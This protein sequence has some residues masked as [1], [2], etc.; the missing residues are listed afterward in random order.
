MF[1]N[2]VEFARANLENCVF[3][4][5]VLAVRRLE[6]VSEVSGLS[7]WGVQERK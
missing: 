1:E 3:C 7:L 4:M 6:S 2:F 5:I